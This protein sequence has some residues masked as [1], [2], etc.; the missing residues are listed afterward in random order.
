MDKNCMQLVEKIVDTG[1]DDAKNDQFNP[2]YEVKIEASIKRV[3]FNVVRSLKYVL[4]LVIL[5]DAC[6]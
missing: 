6:L 2:S 5:I 3:H 1:T 4:G